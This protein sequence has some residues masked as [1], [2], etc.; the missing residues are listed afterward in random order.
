MKETFE[1]VGEH[2]YKRQYQTAGGDWRTKYYA[3]FTDWKGKRRK[4]S[5]GTDEK[6]AR[7]G[8]TIRLAD[9]LKKVDFD[10]EKE[11]R[12]AHEIA[13]TVAGWSEVYFELE[14]VKKKRSVGRDRDYV[15]P[16]TRILGRKLLTDI[17]T[18]DLFG[19]LNKRREEGIIRGGKET[20]TKV[21][22]GTIKNELSCLR[23]MLN[24]AR[25]KRIKTSAVSFLGVI[26]KAQSRE[27][28]LSDSDEQKLFPLLPVWLLRLVEF[29]RETAISEGDLLRL[30][31]DMINEDAGTIELDGGRIKTSVKQVAPLTQRAREILEEIRADRRKAKVKNMAGLIFTRESGKV[32]NKDMITGKIRRAVKAAGLRHFVFHD[33]RHT[34]KTNWARQGIAVDVAMLAAGHSSTQMHQHYVHLQNEDVAKAFGTVQ[35]CSRSVPKKS[36]RRQASL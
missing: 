20:Q 34:A 2:L 14:E 33:L 15:K 8:L 19:Y 10:K 3:I 32:I 22:D 21:A 36:R 5:L 23:R 9:N 17:E 25:S 12:R 1:R 30:T 31:D 28:V 16:L 13:I 6:A 18:D 35:N 27:R 4:F 24:L 29:G 7:Q 11:E 26:P